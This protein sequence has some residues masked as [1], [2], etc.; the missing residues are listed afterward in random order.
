MLN[1][2]HGWTPKWERPLISVE[3]NWKKL[4]LTLETLNYGI[5]LNNIQQCHRYVEEVRGSKLAQPL[6]LNKVVIV[7][8][9]IIIP[10]LGTILGKPQ[11]K[12]D[13]AI[14]ISNNFA[15]NEW[16]LSLKEAASLS[17]F[18]RILSKVTLKYL[19]IRKYQK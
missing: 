7:I 8:F 18:E 15:A 9:M 14:G 13:W 1:H 5:A 2:S 11:P 4:K 6:P 17:S 19:L 12:E 10:D 16:N 3:N